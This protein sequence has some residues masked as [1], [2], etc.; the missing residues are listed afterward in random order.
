[1]LVGGRAVNVIGPGD[2]FGEIALL[3][4]VPRTATVRALTEVELF[5]LDRAPFLEAVTGQPRSR[6]AAQ[7]LVDQRLAADR[8]AA[9]GPAA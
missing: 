6:A 2:G 4:D 7:A 3:N 1:M 8:R 5:V 9:E